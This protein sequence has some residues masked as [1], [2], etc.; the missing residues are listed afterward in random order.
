MTSVK[1]LFLGGNWRGVG[2][3]TDVVN[4]EGTVPVR[5]GIAAFW[6]AAAVLFYNPALVQALMVDQSINSVNM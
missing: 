5:A 3:F 6:V 1:T 4:M 2:C